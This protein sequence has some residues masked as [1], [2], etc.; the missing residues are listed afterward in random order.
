MKRGA[1][2]FAHRDCVNIQDAFATKMSRHVSAYHLGCEPQDF[3]CSVSYNCLNSPRSLAPII[4]KLKKKIYIPFAGCPQ[5]IYRLMCECWNP[6]P[7]ERPAF[8]HMFDRLQR[9]LQ[10]SDVNHFSTIQGLIYLFFVL[11]FHQDVCFHR[12][13]HG[14]FLI[15]FRT[16][17][18]IN[19]EV[20]QRA[21]E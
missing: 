7:T 16:S 3:Q 21:R 9:F 20:N 6:T 14:K 10:V 5:E 18:P 12:K 4:K 19:S 1:L 2:V 15:K 13:G 8:A 17:I 11:W